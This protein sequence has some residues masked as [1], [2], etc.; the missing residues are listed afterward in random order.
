MGP[1]NPAMSAE[2]KAVT[3]AEAQAIMF[4][5]EKRGRATRANRSPAS[6]NCFQ[7]RRPAK[8]LQGFSLLF[9]NENGFNGIVA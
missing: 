9:A 7:C 6:R 2:I 4:L 8:L 5:W 1:T 3:G